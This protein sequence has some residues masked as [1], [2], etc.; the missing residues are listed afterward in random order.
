MNK[1]NLR[2]KR[3]RRIRAK[4]YGTIAIPRL[5][6]FRSNLHIYAQIIND[7]SAQTLA[8]TSDLEIKKTL[9]KSKK[10]KEEIAFIVGQELAKKAKNKKIKKVVFDRGGYKFHGRVKSLADGAR[11]S[12]LIF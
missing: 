12:G 10:T 2:L 4:I 7:E 6:V 11:K 5:T 8:A 9:K 3:K 1:N